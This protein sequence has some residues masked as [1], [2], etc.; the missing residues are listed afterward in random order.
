MDGMRAGYNARA[1]HARQVAAQRGAGGPGGAHPPRLP[2]LGRRDFLFLSAVGDFDPLQEALGSEDHGAAGEG[3]EGH[4]FFDWAPCTCCR[5]CLCLASPSASSRAA[6]R[7]CGRASPHPLCASRALA[8]F[9]WT[10][11]TVAWPG[12]QPPPCAGIL[13]LP[14]PAPAVAAA[15]RWAALSPDGLLAELHSVGRCSAVVRVTPDFSD[16]LMG[17][18]AW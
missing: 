11:A 13:T 3:E 9:V 16:L 17:H 14:H 5:L 2:S 10:H 18:S 6:R 1:E 8:A 12:C 7:P 15:R 4:R